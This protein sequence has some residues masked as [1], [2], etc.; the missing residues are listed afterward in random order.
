MIWW[1]MPLSDLKEKILKHVQQDITAIEKALQENLHGH[2]EL[3]KDVAGHILFSGGKRLRPLLMVLSAR[4]CHYAGNQEYAYSAIFEYL[5]AATLLHDDLVDGGEL[6]RGRTAAHR[7]YG[8]AVAV[9]TGDFL[10]ARS[11][12]IAAKTGLPA[13]I[14][15]IAGITENMSQGEIQQLARKGHNNLSEDEYREIIRRK[16]AVLM[17]GACRVGALVSHAEEAEE[18]ALTAFG[19][20][21]GMAFQMADDLLDY[22]A[23]TDTLGKMAGADLR[24]GKLT[25]P[26]IR[27]L[28]QASAE[29][30]EEMEKIIRR[31]DFSPAEFE[32]LLALMHTYGGIAYTR[33]Q[34]EKHVRKARRQLA[35]F[36]DSETKEI[37]GDIAGYALHRKQ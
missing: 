14:A 32:K 15:A 1:E 18:K 20:H 12:S 13:V 4:L 11:L 27:S 7:I 34:A 23:D 8:N 35:L 21:L 10:L 5:H 37:L 30:R 28:A 16:T 19:F 33:Q 26:V 29:D 24:E 2:L 36:P 22:T 25:L 9:L 31:N 3:V 6:R 17:E